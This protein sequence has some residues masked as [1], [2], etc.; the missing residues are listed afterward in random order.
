MVPSWSETFFFPI[1]PG[2]CPN[3]FFNKPFFLTAPSV[4]PLFVTIDSFGRIVLFDL[5]SH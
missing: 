1:K 3:N 4:F 5:V 2:V